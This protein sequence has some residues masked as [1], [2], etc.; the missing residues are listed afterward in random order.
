MSSLPLGCDFVT[1]L[2][3]DGEHRKYTAIKSLTRLLASSIS[4]H[5]CK[6]HFCLTCLQGFQYKES[7]D[8]H[9]EYCKDNESVRIEMPKE[10]SFVKFQDG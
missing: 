8:K 1:S 5:K 2:I 3:G 4:K 9:S 7:R 10:G 6:Q